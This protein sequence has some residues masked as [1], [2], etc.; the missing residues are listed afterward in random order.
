MNEE[1]FSG[2]RAR[3][4][5]GLGVELLGV[6]P[7]EQISEDE[8][9]NAHEA[10]F[11]DQMALGIGVVERMPIEIEPH[12]ASTGLDQQAPRAARDRERGG[13]VDGRTLDEPTFVVDAVSREELPRVR[14]GRSALAVVEDRTRHGPLMIARGPSRRKGTA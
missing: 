3:R 2:T 12:H 9:G 11:V 7:Y 6:A 13:A 5:Q 10:V 4:L 1:N 8:H 14:A